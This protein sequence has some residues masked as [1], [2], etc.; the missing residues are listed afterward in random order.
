MAYARFGRGCDVYV[1]ASLI[2]GGQLVCE[3]CPMLGQ[4]IAP[5][6]EDMKAHLRE[7]ALM[8]HQVPESVF[9]AIDQETE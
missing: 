3:S 7:H 4:Y 2:Y 8:G 9:D 6:R 5:S 1:Y